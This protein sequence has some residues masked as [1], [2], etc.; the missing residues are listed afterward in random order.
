MADILLT[1]NAS[2]MPMNI[3]DI[4]IGLPGLP[5][6]K[7]DP[8]EPGPPGDPG[9]KGDKGDP[10]D[11]GAVGKSIEFL[12]NGTQ[13][14]IRVVGTAEYTF[15]DL[16]GAPGELGAKG[17]KGDPG[18]QGVPGIDGVNGTN[19]YT[20]VR[21]TDYWTSADVAGMESYIN[22]YID[23]VILGGTS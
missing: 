1:I 21:G 18:A 10:G 19:G 3:G 8:G 5:G 4:R 7:G 15:V 22:N 13:L 9:D 14:G 20:P 23:V 2:A 16:K 12:W 17:D 6:P 11:T